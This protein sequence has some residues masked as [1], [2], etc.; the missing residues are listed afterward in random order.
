MLKDRGSFYHMMIS[1]RGLGLRIGKDKMEW[2]HTVVKMEAD[3]AQV[4]LEVVPLAQR[5]RQVL[6]KDSFWLFVLFLR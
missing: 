3:Q 4:D 1:L 5:C 6:N 2:T